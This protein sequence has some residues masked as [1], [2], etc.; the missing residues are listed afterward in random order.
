VLPHYYAGCDSGWDNATA[1]DHGVPVITPDLGAYLAVQADVI[2]DLG[3]RLGRHADAE[4]WRQQAGVLVEAL[5]GELWNGERFV[6]RHAVTRE[7]VATESLIYCMPILLGMRLPE[8]VRAALVN[9]LRG[10][11]TE[12][13]LASEHPESPSYEPDG[14]WRGPIWGSAT[15]L[16]VD[17]LIACGEADMARDITRR[18]CRLC[19]HE[20]FAENFDAKAGRSQKDP[21]YTWT[22]SA[23]MVLAERLTHGEQRS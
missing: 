19:A 5:L 8:A 9:Q 13:G 2:A 7:T 17:G 18:F 15:L 3:V 16:I 11:V 14:Y 10:F 6:A 12:W 20:G 21:G 22:A 1:F 23:F 4:Y